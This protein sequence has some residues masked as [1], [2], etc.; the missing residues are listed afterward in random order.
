[1]KKLLLSLALAGSL[2]AAATVTVESSI[3]QKDINEKQSIVNRQQSEINL[4][5]EKINDNQID[6][7]KQNKE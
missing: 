6:A 5:Q 4:I 7:N 1:M 2:L 3:T